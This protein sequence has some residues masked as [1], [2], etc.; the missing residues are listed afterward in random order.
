M[1]PG[2]PPALCGSGVPCGAACR[3]TARTG[4]L[5]PQ[6]EQSHETNGLVLSPPLLAGASFY[7]KAVTPALRNLNPSLCRESSSHSRKKYLQRS[8][9][10]SSHKSRD[11][12]IKP[13]RTER[14]LQ[15]GS[16]RLPAGSSGLRHAHPGSRRAE[17]PC[18]RLE[19]PST[20]AQPAQL[21]RHGA[22]SAAFQTLPRL[23]SHASRGRCLPATLEGYADPAHPSSPGQL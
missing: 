3:F 8:H 4:N 10:S 22:A 9:I 19:V 11:K 5:L 7:K 12:E 20:A 16:A 23:Q 1:A 21:P 6:G 15:Q 18:S 17:T 2:F 14:A 13:Q